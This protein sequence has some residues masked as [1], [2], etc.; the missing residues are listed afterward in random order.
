MMRL[1]AGYI[2]GKVEGLGLLWTRGMRTYW[3]CINVGGCGESC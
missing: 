1:A 3:Y 2:G